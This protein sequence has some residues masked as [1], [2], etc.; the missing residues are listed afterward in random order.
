MKILK[1]TDITFIKDQKY[2]LTLEVPREY[3]GDNE[4]YIDVLYFGLFR[5]DHCSNFGNL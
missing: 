3:Y 4:Y 1:L 2:K 5:I